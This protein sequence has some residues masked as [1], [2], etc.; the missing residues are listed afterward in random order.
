MFS[1]SFQQLIL[2]IH[3]SQWTMKCLGNQKKTNGSYRGEANIDF[4]KN[5][6]FLLCLPLRK[7][8]KFLTQIQGAIFVFYKKKRKSKS[9]ALN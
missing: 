5:V 1:T 3:I 7:Q 4:S 6:K 9:L 8:S 2:I